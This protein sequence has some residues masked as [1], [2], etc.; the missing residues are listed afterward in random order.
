MSRII[1]RQVVFGLFFLVTLP[2]LSP[3][4]VCASAKRSGTLP[5]FPGAQGF[6]TETSAGRGGIILKVTNLKNSGKGSL[7]AAIKE[8]RPRIIV[9]EVGGT[10]ELKK[11]LKIKDPFVTIAGQTAPSPGITL[12]GAG[13][14]ISSHDVLV[15]H[16]R[17]RVGDARKGPD[18]E[19]REGLKIVGKGTKVYNVVCDHL[20]VSWGV[21][22]VVSTVY[23]PRE[24]TISNSII[25]EGLHDSL[26]PKGKHSKALLLREGTQD[27]AL[28]GN[29]FAHNHDRNPRITGDSSVVA[30]NNLL[31]NAGR[32]L[33]FDVAPGTHGV[34][35]PHLLSVV[36]N[37]F[38]EGPN[39]PHYA[40][41]IRVKKDC[42][43]GTKIYHSDNLATGSILKF[44]T[45]FD[46]QVFS[47]PAW[48]PSIVPR[49]GA[50]VEFLVLSHAGARPA[51]RD[52]VDRRIVKEMKARRGSIIN[53]VQDVGGW[54][55]L[56][57]AFRSFRIPADPGGDRDGDGYTNIEEL[58]HLMAG[59][60][61]GKVFYEACKGR[62]GL[63]EQP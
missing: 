52:A 56:T 53:S 63:M 22:E 50:E 40:W 47:P 37:V 43:P 20:S 17:I 30:V 62:C 55:I 10:I 12:K 32:R 34:R 48:H 59:K 2:F 18:P 11:N 26:H 4:N 35:G 6:G 58:L 36:G 61:E 3:G 15:Q 9:F 5:V 44:S 21:D 7:R 41:P 16:L 13:L 45:P 1:K 14:V 42:L 46:P 49:P 54:P 31:Y 24:V 8:R 29:F 51:D 39:T 28:I 38:V 57:T 33:W 27:L 60:L 23:G 19:N 25:S